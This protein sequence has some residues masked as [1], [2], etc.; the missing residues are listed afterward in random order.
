MLRAV[1]TMAFCPFVRLHHPAMPFQS[2]RYEAGWWWNRQSC[3][4]HVGQNQEPVRQ[5]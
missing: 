2:R 5:L 3:V 4:D 1:M